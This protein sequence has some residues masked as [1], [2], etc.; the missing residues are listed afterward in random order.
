LRVEWTSRGRGNASSNLKLWAHFIYVDN[1]FFFVLPNL[2]E[3]ALLLALLFRLL[4]F[5]TSS[6]FDFL[7]FYSFFSLSFGFILKSWCLLFCCQPL[8]VDSN[9]IWHDIQSLPL[10]VAMCI[11]RCG[12]GCGKGCGYWCG[13]EIEIWYVFLSVTQHNK[14]NG[15]SFGLTW[16]INSFW[17]ACEWIFIWANVWTC[18]KNF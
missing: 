2:E 9:N 5:L 15:N 6:Y 13:Y 14:W 16:S 7:F 17:L 1:R 11:H 3:L 10:T 8:F 4:L 12:K 18:I